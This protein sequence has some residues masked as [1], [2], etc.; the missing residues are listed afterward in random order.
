MSRFLKGFS[1]TIRNTNE[2]SAFWRAFICYVFFYIL[3]RTC[4]STSRYVNTSYQNGLSLL[5]GFGRCNRVSQAGHEGCDL[6][7]LPCSIR[8]QLCHQQ[9]T[10]LKSQPCHLLAMC[11]FRA[12]KLTDPNFHVIIF[13]LNNN[14]CPIMQ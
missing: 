12:D 11:E 4:I 1:T 10:A 7:E 9:D 8:D 14:T 2:I 5:S 13:K 6:T 3:S